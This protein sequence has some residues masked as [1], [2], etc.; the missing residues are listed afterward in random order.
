[1]AINEVNATVLSSLAAETQGQVAPAGDIARGVAESARALEGSGGSGPAAD[2]A[3]A[4]VDTQ[5]ASLTAVLDGSVNVLNQLAPDETST[6]SSGTHASSCAA[7]AGA[8]PSCPR[9]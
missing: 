8:A 2:A 4:D 1:M 9:P 6:A 3:R 7:T 5:L